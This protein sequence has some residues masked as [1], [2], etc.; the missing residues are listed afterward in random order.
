MSNFISGSPHFGL[1]PSGFTYP[2]VSKPE[3]LIVNE[4]ALAFDLRKE[5]SRSEKEQK[6]HELFNKSVSVKKM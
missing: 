5:D 2:P 4:E 6:I 3:H 1:P